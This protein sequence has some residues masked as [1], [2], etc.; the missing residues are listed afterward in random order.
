MANWI[1]PTPTR[2]GEAALTQAQVDSWRERGYAFVAGLFPNTVVETLRAAAATLFPAPDT[3]EA[4]TVTDFGSGGRLTFPS[5]CDAFNAVTLHPRLLTAIGQLLGVAATELR[6][7][8]SDLWPKYGRHAG[9]RGPTDNDDQRM[10]VDYP[11]HTL[12][13]PPPW[14]T[15]E[16]V[17]LIL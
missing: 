16:A 5:R 11:N 15:P 6:L 3:A 7:T 17:E 12:A 10:H 13:H 4:D 8:Q 2:P 14:R 1:D 9:D